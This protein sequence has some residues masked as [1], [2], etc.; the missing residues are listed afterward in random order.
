MSR[1]K[2]FPI[3]REAPALAERP[4]CRGCHKPLKP[5]YVERFLVDNDA[6][7]TSCGG[8]GAVTVDW[9]VASFK[10]TRAKR[11]CNVCK[12]TGRTVRH[13]P[14]DRVW[15]GEYDAWAGLYCGQLCAARHAAALWHKLDEGPLTMSAFGKALA[16]T[17]AAARAAHAAKL[18]FQAEG[19][20]TPE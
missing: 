11:P 18:V 20:V 15:A 9:S 4:K 12:G 8:K 13:I 1:A 2:D 17:E 19:G 5:H 10:D 3:T 14:K 16:G 7:C 6:E